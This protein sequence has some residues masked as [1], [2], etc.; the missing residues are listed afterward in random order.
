MTSD[1]D[2][3]KLLNP[4]FEKFTDRVALTRVGSAQAGMMTELRYGLTLKEGISTAEFLE[5][6]H[7]ASGNNR[8]VLTPTGHE[9]DM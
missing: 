6:L 7:L 9:I 8:V 4:V 1:M 5:A 3:E 2:F